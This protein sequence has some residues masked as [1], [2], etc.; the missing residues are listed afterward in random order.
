MRRSLS[1]LCVE[2][3]WLVQVQDVS[4]EDTFDTLVVFGEPR[5]IGT[6]GA[7]PAGVPL[8]FPSASA[9]AAHHRTARTPTMLPFAAHCPAAGLLL[10]LAA[11]R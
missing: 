4:I 7:N 3:L 9:A 8:P 2:P 6:E 11:G 1:R 5:W 10:L